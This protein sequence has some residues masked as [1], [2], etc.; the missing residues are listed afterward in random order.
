MESNNQKN[1][2]SEYPKWDARMKST[3]K[4]L[5]PNMLPWHFGII[6]EVLKLEGYDVEILQNG[7][8][9]FITIRV[10]PV[11]ALSGSIL[12]HLKAVITI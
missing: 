5:V 7:L 6:E 2:T 10:T 1:Y 8:N 4:I 9:M 11:F 12:T 3:H